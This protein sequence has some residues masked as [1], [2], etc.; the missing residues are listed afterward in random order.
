MRPSICDLADRTDYPLEGIDRPHSESFASA[1]RHHPEAKSYVQAAQ[2]GIRTLLT[3]FGRVDLD[4][5]SYT[6]APA[7]RMV[8]RPRSAT[9]FNLTTIEEQGVFA[10]LPGAPPDSP[11]MPIRDIAPS[12]LGIV[13]KLVAMRADRYISGEPRVCAR[14]SSYAQRI[15]SGRAQRRRDG[16]GGEIRTLVDYFGPSKRPQYRYSTNPSRSPED[17]LRRR[18]L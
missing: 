10:R 13:A 17:A 9:A 7:R 3:S 14:K 8:H 1:I 11:L 18:R 6:P 4:K 5:L 12:L 2:L 15:V 16:I